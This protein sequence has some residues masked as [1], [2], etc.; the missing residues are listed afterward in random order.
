MSRWRNPW[1]GSV[2][3][4]L[5]FVE[6]APESREETTGKTHDHEDESGGMCEV[7]E[8]TMGYEGEQWKEKT[9]ANRW[10]VVLQLLEN[11]EGR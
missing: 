2:G 11:G 8:V 5:L 6:G 9:L 10:Q 7:A 1:L 3:L 4:R